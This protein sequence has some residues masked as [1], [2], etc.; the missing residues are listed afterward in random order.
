MDIRAAILQEHSKKQA[1]LIANY[2]SSNQERFDQL[3]H[4][5]LTDEYRVVQ[6]AAY[7]VSHCADRHIEMVYP[8]LPAM[9]EYLKDRSTHIATRRNIV[10]I[11]SQIDVPEPLMGNVATLCFDFLIDPKEAVA[12][13]IYSMEVLY[14]LTL[15]EPDLQNELILV[16][17]ENMIHGSAGIRSRGRKVLKRLD[18]LGL[19]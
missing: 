18:K 9:V 7:A 10:R 5:F 15:K 19:L 1:L 8:H 11:L 6:R 16:I 14:Q 2:I 4:L 13:K 3:M 12:V 17:E